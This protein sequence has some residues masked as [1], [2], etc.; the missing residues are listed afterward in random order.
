MII[1]YLSI[2]IVICIVLCI[3]A[4]SKT[5]FII[6]NEQYIKNEQYITIDREKKPFFLIHISKTGGTFIENYLKKSHVNVGRFDN[7]LKRMS[8]NM[9]IEC[10]KYHIPPKYFPSIDF[11]KLHTFTVIRHP[12]ERIISEYNYRKTFFGKNVHL[13]INDFVKQNV[14]K[15]N[16]MFDCHLIP[17]HEYIKDL[18][19]NSCEMFLRFEHLTHD[20]KWYCRQHNIP[21]HNK[22]VKKLKSKPIANQNQMTEETKQ[23]VLN[24]YQKDLELW[25]RAS[26]NV[27]Y[28]YWDSGFINAPEIIQIC[29]QSWKIM[30]P[31]WVLIELNRDNLR[32]YITETDMQFLQKQ[33]SKMTKTSFSDLI[34]LCLLKE[35]GGLWVDATLFCMKPLNEWIHDSSSNGFFAFYNPLQQISSFFLYAHIE[36]HVIGKWFKKM[37]KYW[38]ERKEMEEYFWMHRLF[39]KCYQDDE[40]FRENIDK[41]TKINTIPIHEYQKHGILNANTPVQK[42]NYK[43]KIKVSI[44]QNFLSKKKN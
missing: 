42:L 2:F 27:I 43:K 4:F 22:K 14:Y 29:L 35:H 24:F 6:T 21:I 34:R 36:S 30:N 28:I 10:S 1:I 40:E 23:F 25:K 41:M 5:K 33:E 16:T 11:K 17:Q 26:T 39:R 7:M 15:N 44:L 37:K 20:L 31:T 18:H 12:L 3:Y 13:G 19:G 9:T 32:D 38:I 8:N